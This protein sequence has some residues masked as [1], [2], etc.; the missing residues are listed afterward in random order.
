[1]TEPPAAPAAIAAPKKPK[2]EELPTTH[3][4]AGPIQALVAQSKGFVMPLA[5]E[6]DVHVELG[7]PKSFGF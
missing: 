7:K 2:G 3:S 4:K 5:L 1:M 6:Q